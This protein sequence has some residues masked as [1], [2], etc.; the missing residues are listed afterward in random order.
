MLLRPEA[1]QAGFREP[2]THCWGVGNHVEQGQRQSWVP[3]SVGSA[4]HGWGSGNSTNSDPSVI[5]GESFNSHGQGEQCDCHEITLRFPWFH[6]LSLNV[7]APESQRHLTY[8]NGIIFALQ[9]IS[10]IGWSLFGNCFSST[11]RRAVVLSARDPHRFLTKGRKTGSRASHRHTR[12]RD[13]IHCDRGANL[14]G[15]LFFWSPLS[16]PTIKQ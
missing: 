2:S 7:L 15:H 3:L 6:K 5:P 14:R 12:N 16:I 8:I 13:D 11:W 1:V 9:L 4:Q 10:L